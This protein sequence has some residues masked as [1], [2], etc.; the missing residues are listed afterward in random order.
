MRYPSVTIV[1]LVAELIA[2]PLGI[3]LAKTL[4]L[5][6]IN[7]GRLGSWCINPDRHF[8]I[9]EHTVIVIMSNVSFG[10]G[11]PDASSLI[12]AAKGFYGF[13]LKPGFSVLVV[14]CCQLL[15]FGI[16][17]LAAPLLVEPA[18]II[19]PGILSNCA[20]LSTLHSR[21]NTVANGWKISRNRFFLYTMAGSGV[22]Y[23]FPG[24]MFVGLSYFTWICW[25]APNNIL[26]N[27]I[28]G[29]VSGLGVSPI[30]FDWSQIAYNSNP[31]LAPTWAGKFVY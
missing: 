26:V 9:K 3:A 13:S 1:S 27:Q 24:F 2:F 23:L 8:N 10:N 15:G 6:T 7:L 11:S 4:P 31:L 18:A 22:W 21:G 30:T 25:I 16:A 19:W 12:Q 29:M 17:G 20:I 5:Y 28:F 14:L